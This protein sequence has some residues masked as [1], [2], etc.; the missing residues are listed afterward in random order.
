MLKYTYWVTRF[1]ELHVEI[2]YKPRKQ[3]QAG[4][5][6]SRTPVQGLD[7]HNIEN[8]ELIS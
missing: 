6:L 3:N 7:L 1:V 2:I 4:G 5:S 8:Q